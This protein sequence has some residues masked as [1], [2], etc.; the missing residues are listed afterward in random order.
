MINK[1]DAPNSPKLLFWWK[2]QYK[3]LFHEKE[4]KWLGKS[5]VYNLTLQYPVGVVAWNAHLLAAIWR[6]ILQYKKI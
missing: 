3:S 2:Y 1:L 6:K 4:S 5:T